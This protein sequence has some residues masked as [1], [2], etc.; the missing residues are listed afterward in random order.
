MQE[1][2]M[3]AQMKMQFKMIQGCFT[4]CVSS[5]REDALTTREKTCLGNCAMREIN[6]FQAMAA[7]Q[8]KM[9]QGQGMQGGPQF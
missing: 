5:F 8:Q 9:M 1:F 6:S 3:K 7:I 4:D 2:E